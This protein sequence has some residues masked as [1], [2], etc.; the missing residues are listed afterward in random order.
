[1]ANPPSPITS[2]SKVGLET[3]YNVLLVLER[4]QLSVVLNPSAV[5]HLHC[6]FPSHHE[7]SPTLWFATAYLFV[8][9]LP[10]SWPA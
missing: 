3:C 2:T 9:L 7:L 4:E 5:L 10:C 8:S 1:M 6:Y